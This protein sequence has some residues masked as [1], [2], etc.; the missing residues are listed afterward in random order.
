MNLRHDRCDWN[1]HRPWRLVIVRRLWLG[2]LAL[3]R[4]DKIGQPGEA[5]GDRKTFPALTAFAEGVGL[6]PPLL[7]TLPVYFW[8][9]TIWHRNPF[10]HG[11]LVVVIPPVRNPIKTKRCAER[12]ITFAVPG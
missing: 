10:A 11:Q 2:T 4:V 1:F 9:P 5:I 6:F 8:V 3:P 7:S 12:R